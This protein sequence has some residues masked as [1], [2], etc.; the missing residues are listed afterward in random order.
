[1]DFASKLRNPK[2][3]FFP[4]TLREITKAIARGASSIVPTSQPIKEDDKGSDEADSKA[5]L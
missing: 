1:M 4:L 3:V 2:K 5:A